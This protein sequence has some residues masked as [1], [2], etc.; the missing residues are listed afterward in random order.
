MKIYLLK[1]IRTNNFTDTEMGAKIS[2][3]WQESLAMIGGQSVVTYGIYHNYAG[4]Y[5]D[6]YDLSIGTEIIER[7]LSVTVS[8]GEKYQAFPVNLAAENPVF[9]AWQ[10]IWQQEEQ[11]DLK[12][13]Y[14]IDYEEYA[15][16][17][18]ITIYISVK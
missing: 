5:R 14:G 3:A 10:M 4:N 12:R 17:G 16:D 13:D 8:D 15:S 6:D 9:Q 11:G 18:S 2:E 7:P 1:T